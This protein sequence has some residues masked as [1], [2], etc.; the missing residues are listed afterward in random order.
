MPSSFGSTLH[1]L[2]SLDTGVCS[3]TKKKHCLE[4]SGIHLHWGLGRANVG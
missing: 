2:W 1:K 3:I 4:S